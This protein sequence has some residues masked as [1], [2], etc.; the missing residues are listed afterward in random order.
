MPPG[1]LESGSAIKSPLS[2]EL[3]CKQKEKP[4]ANCLSTGR[5]RVSQNRNVSLLPTHT[6]FCGRP[7][8]RR[9]ARMAMMYAMMQGSAGMVNDSEIL[10]VIF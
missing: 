10:L 5:R 3:L 7:Q 2:S 1:I 4:A 6:S 8:S 9:A